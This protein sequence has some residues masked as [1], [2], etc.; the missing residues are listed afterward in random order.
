MKTTLT[1]L[2]VTVTTFSGVPGKL[3]VI[4][5]QQPP[6]AKILKAIVAPMQKKTDS[7][8]V[9]YFEQINIRDEAT[10]KLIHEMK[11]KEAENA[12]LKYELKKL[13]SDHKCVIVY[14][15]DTVF[16]KRKFLQLFKN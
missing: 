11:A 10:D 6:P 7:L 13:R 8:K 2:L 14:I 12:K 3:D 9:A 4:K 16:K 15:H 5:I 1:L